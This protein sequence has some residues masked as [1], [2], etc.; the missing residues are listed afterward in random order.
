MDEIKFGEKI[1]LLRINARYTQ[2][3]FCDLLGIPQSTLSAYE[4]DRMMPTLGALI[5]IASKFNVSMDWLCGLERNTVKFDTVGDV[6][7]AIYDMTEIEG[8]KID[9]T[10]HDKLPNDIETETE[11]W[12]VQMRV[13]GNDDDNPHNADFCNAVKK[14]TENIADLESYAISDDVYEAEKEKC[15]AYN[16]IPVT[17]KKIP[18]L[19]R[20]ER[21]KK[22][23]EWIKKNIAE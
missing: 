8:L 1:K 7:G 13:Y 20:D 19:S 3:E 18:Q 15:T 16:K 12:Y 14:L 17:K 22:H 10:V 23:L 9:F 11:R 2:K 5:N 4:T 21:M 6:I